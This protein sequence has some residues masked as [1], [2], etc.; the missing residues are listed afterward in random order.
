MV[1]EHGDNHKVDLSQMF[2]KC[3]GSDNVVVVE[4]DGFN[5]KRKKPQVYKEGEAPVPEPVHM[6]QPDVQQS[7]GAPMQLPKRGP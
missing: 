1:W 4:D 7:F 3:Q 5:S 2:D 6:S